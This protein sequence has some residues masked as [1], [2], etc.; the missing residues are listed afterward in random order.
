M[1]SLACLRG[2]TLL[3]A[4]AAGLNGE[5]RRALDEH[6]RQ[7]PGCREEARLLDQIAADLT[8]VPGLGPAARERTLERALRQGRAQDGARPRA[9]WKMKVALAGGAMAVAGAVTVLLAGGGRHATPAP[10]ASKPN[11]MPSTTSAP[12]APQ[13][14]AVGGEVVLAHARVHA[15][16]AVS[17]AWEEKTATVRLGAGAIEI[18]VDPARRRW[19]RVATDSFVVEV[20]GTH[21]IVDSGHVEVTRGAVRILSPD[22]S[23]IVARLQA[24]Q[25]WSLP[26]PAP[27]PAPEPRAPSLQPFAAAQQLARARRDLAEGHVARAEREASSVLARSTDRREEAEAR[28]LLAE[29]ARSTGHTDQA[30]ATYAAIAKRFGDLPAGETALFAAGR[31]LADSGHRAPAAQ[32]LHRYLDRYPKGRFTFEAKARLAEIEGTRP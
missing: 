24:G 25:T 21:F 15:I 22:G 17:L 14:L 2:G 4:R 9:A 10:L 11:A 23:V 3:A 28:T 5:Q 6:L 27:A 18:D 8:S 1:R 20:L 12:S 32:W 31:T 29:C 7:C 30:I 19:F 26:E 16:R 13:T